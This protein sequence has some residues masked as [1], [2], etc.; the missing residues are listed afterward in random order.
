MN[1]FKIIATLCGTFLLA[2]CIREYSMVSQPYHV[3]NASD[4]AGASKK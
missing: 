3:Q 2:L 4:I 1:Y